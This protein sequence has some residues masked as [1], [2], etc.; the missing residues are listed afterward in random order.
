MQHSA[1][2]LQIITKMNAIANA[3]IG[4]LNESDALIVCLDSPDLIRRG[5]VSGGH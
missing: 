4:L 5:I 2:I 1:Q 3:H